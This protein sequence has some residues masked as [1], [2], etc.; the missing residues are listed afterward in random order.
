MALMW[1][2]Y[3]KILS[4]MLIQAYWSRRSWDQYINYMGLYQFVHNSAILS[5][6]CLLYLILVKLG[7]YL[8]KQKHKTEIIKQATSYSF[9]CHRHFYI[10]HCTTRPFSLSKRK[11]IITIGY[12]LQLARNIGPYFNQKWNLLLK[13]LLLV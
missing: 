9:N 11:W 6:N 10:T 5:A 3:T 8:M 7:L 1:G 2:K 13:V 12:K 4:P